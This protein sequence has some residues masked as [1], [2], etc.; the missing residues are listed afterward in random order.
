MPC[1]GCS[2][3]AWPREVSP[4][5]AWLGRDAQAGPAALFLGGMGAVRPSLAISSE[6]QPC[7]SSHVVRVRPALSSAPAHG[8]SCFQVVEIFQE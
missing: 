8:C 5:L 2:G 7:P 4:S 1:H 6:R 3:S